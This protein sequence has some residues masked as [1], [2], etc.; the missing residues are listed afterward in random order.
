MQ[1]FI[2]QGRVQGVG[3]RAWSATEA[4]K[5]RLRGWVRN[6]SDGSVEIFV[7]EA[8]QAALDDFEK[9]LWKGPIF[10][11]VKQLTGK[12]ISISQLDEQLQTLHDEFTVLA[13]A[14]VPAI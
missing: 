10:A 2:V 14:D 7:Q 4:K 12:P 11:S 3:Y 1:H 6:L 9:A 13:T 5:R 8:T